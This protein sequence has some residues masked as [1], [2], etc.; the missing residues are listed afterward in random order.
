MKHSALITTLLAL[1]LVACD[2]KPAEKPFVPDPI[3]APPSVPTPAPALP[4]GHPQVNPNSTMGAT[5]NMGNLPTIN[6]ASSESVNKATVVSIIN[7]PQFTYIEIGEGKQTE[8]L[9][10][11]TVAVKKG[12]V[13]QFEGGTTMT[14]FNSKALNR[15]FPSLTLVNHVTVISGK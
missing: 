8:W 12:D 11:S 2:S 3:V 6:S 15:T 5:G 1:S 4:P 14:N 7:V 9:A 13:I 10:T